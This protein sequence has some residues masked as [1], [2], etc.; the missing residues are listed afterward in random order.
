M[1]PPTARRYR[2][3][4]LLKDAI[5]IDTVDVSHEKVVP[6]ES[7][8]C[9]H[10]INHKFLYEKLS[11]LGVFQVTLKVVNLVEHYGKKI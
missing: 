11:K 5:D 1:C 6:M 9:L 10:I 3:T 4:F 8:D 2:D 7:W